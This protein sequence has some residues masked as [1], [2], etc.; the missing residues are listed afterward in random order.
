[1]AKLLI[2][3]VAVVVSL[4]IALGSPI[5]S[6]TAIGL[7]ILSLVAILWLTEALPIYTTALLVPLLAMG[8]GVLDAVTALKNFASPIIFLFLGGFTLA[9][10]MREHKL[11]RWMAQNLMGLAKGRFLPSSLLLFLGTAFLSMWMSNTAVAA[12]AL[13]LALGL[14][15]P[16]REAPRSTLVFV[17]L[18]TAYSASIGGI[19]TLIG[20]PPNAIAASVIGIDFL[21]WLQI[22]LPLVGVLL[23][24]M[25]LILW[26]TLRPTVPPPQ[27]LE[28]ERVVWS[29]ST[30][31]VLGVFLMTAGFWLFGQPLASGLGIDKDFDALIAIAAIVVLTGLR[32]V[33]WQALTRDT[34]WKV[35]IL[36]GGGITLSEVLVSTGASAY[37]AEPLLDLQNTVSPIVFLLLVVG[38]A[39]FLTELASNTATAALL[40]PIFY[41]LPS[42]QSGYS[43][44]TLALTLAVAVSCAFM[45]PVATPPNALV[46]GTGLIEQKEMMR[47]GLRLNIVFIF[48]IT[49]VT[50][51]II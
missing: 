29:T 15:G 13:P 4:T 11:D 31:L 12:L 28:A 48:L 8:A 33:S 6:A 26:V 32:L 35:L 10:A 43:S 30:W 38:M 47:I 2:F 39:I 19:G 24:A 25:V 23:P 46:F 20:S 49:L 21:S 37:L 5:D 50:G 1:M 18:G 7:G 22:G 16:V 45:L 3:L 51:A 14:V 27:P 41:A 9:S 42:V 34:D 40:I 17:L 36:F 44:D